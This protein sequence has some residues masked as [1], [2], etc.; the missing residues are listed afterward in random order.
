MRTTL[1]IVKY[2]Q[3]Q[4]ERWWHEIDG[5]QTTSRYALCYKRVH[6]NQYGHCFWHTCICTKS[7]PFISSEAKFY[8]WQLH[9][10]TSSSLCPD[11]KREIASI[12]ILSFHL[13]FSCQ[14]SY[15]SLLLL[16]ILLCLHYYLYRLDSTIYIYLL[17]WNIE[18]FKR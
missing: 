11:S 16:W 5:E 4:L 14:F 1:V 10:F 13:L 18:F 3:M 2:F 7:L 15:N 6:I 8:T 17:N 9:R 12:Y